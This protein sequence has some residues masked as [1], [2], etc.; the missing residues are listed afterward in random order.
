MEVYDAYTKVLDD[1]KQA[2]NILENEKEPE[3]REMAKME[4]EELKPE[5]ERIE[6]ELKKC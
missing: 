6:D 1:I 5:K 2:K 3:F 4:W